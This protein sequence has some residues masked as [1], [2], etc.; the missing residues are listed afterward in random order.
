MNDFELRIVEESEGNMVLQY[1]TKDVWPYDTVPKLD[2][3]TCVWSAWKAVPVF[4]L[5]EY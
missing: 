5:G 2:N 4:K 3:R 1:K